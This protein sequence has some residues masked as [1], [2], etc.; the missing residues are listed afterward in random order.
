M[1]YHGQIQRVIGT[2]GG[3]GMRT[4]AEIRDELHELLIKRAALLMEW[5]MLDG[6]LALAKSHRME[7]ESLIAQRSPEQVARMQAAIDKA[8]ETF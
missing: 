4:E 1:P 8:V 3:E 6:F 2:A 7:M 5:A